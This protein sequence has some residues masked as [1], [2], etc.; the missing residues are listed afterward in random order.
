[1]YA[2]TS[3]EER[4][5][6][7]KSSAARRVVTSDLCRCPQKSVAIDDKS[8]EH[9][10]RGQSQEQFTVQSEIQIDVPVK[11]GN[12]NR[13]S[14]SF[15]AFLDQICPLNAFSFIYRSEPL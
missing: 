5:D 1:M 6:G 11:I 3:G 15:L 4:C 13:T 10:R 8:G 12:D 2:F 14:T 7:S 9:E